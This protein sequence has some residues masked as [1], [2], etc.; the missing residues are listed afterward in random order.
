MSSYQGAI[1]GSQKARAKEHAVN[2]S[3]RSLTLCKKPVSESQLLDSRR[4]WDR[5][6]GNACQV[7]IDRSDAAEV[8]F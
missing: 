7:C 5:D 4:E 1:I 6:G 2:R 3:N 8:G